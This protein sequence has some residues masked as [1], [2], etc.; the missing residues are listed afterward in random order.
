MDFEYIP[1]THAAEKSGYIVYEER[2][3][4]FVEEFNAVGVHWSQPQSLSA[5]YFFENIN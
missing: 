3:Y 5:F 1:K 4:S 2:F